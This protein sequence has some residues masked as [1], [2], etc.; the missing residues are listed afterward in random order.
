MAAA[1]SAIS[2]SLLG[3]NSCS[4]G[5]S[6]RM[7]TGRPAMIS[8]SS[9]KSPRCMGSSFASAARRPCFGVG[10]DHLAHGQ[11]PLALEEHMLGAAEPDAFGAEGARHAR[12]GRRLGI[13]AHLHAARGIRPFHDGGEIAREFGL[14]HGDRAFQH[15]AAPPSMV[16]TSPFFKCLAG[17]QQRAVLLVDAQDP[18]PR[19]RACPCRAPPRPRGWSCRRAWSGCLRRHACRECLPGSS[20]RAPG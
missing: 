9:A 18:R 13:G 5:S 12:I 20:R 6:R 2:A 10:Q 17:G 14:Q 1:T 16:I 3:R 7:V 8:K 11:N 15:L 4:G 19:R